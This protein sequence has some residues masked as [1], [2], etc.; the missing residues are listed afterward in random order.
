[1][2]VKVGVAYGSDVDAVRKA[3]LDVAA[4]SKHLAEDPEPRVRFREFGDSS[5]NFELLGWIDE[6]VLRGPALDELNTAVYHRFRQDG[7]QIPF[8][9][10]D[11]HVKN[12]VG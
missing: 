3:L 9:Q 11:V 1:M 12:D 2:R 6:P 7:I 4:Q 5:L 8:P 10:R